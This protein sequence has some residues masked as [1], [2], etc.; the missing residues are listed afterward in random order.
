VEEVVELVEVAR[1]D[2]GTEFIWGKVAPNSS[3]LNEAGDEIE[4]VEDEDAEVGDAEG[5][6]K[7]VVEADLVMAEVSWGWEV[8][9]TD[10]GLE[11]GVEEVVVM[12]GAEGGTE[13]EIVEVA[14][15][16]E[17]V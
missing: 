9:E 10:V 8:E 3:L 13:E 11:A 15:V 7:V 5:E 1:M 4:V 16:V 14:E 12:V 2:E 17:V 6:E